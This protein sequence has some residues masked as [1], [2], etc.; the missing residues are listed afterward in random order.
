MEVVHSGGRTVGT[1]AW[2]PRGM[3]SRTT[4]ATVHT[5]PEAV[6]TRPLECRSPSSIAWTISEAR[7]TGAGR[8]AGH[9]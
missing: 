6:S 7:W 1:S 9:F 4:P 5:V 2:C 3:R 8:R